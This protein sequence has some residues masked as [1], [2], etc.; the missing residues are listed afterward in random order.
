[1]PQK[2]SINCFKWVTIS[3]NLMKISWK[4]YGG[5]SDEFGVQYFEELHE[6]QSFTIFARDNENLKGW[7]SCR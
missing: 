2:L 5:D 4:S 7:K 3:L 1:M 6:L